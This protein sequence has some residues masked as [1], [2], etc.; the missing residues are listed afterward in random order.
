MTNVRSKGTFRAQA[1]ERSGRAAQSKPL[2]PRCRD[3]RLPG[4]HTVMLGGLSTF[5]CDAH[6]VDDQDE[7]ECGVNEDHKWNPGDLECRRCGADLSK[8]NEEE[9]SK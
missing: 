4:I 2:P 9:E 1:A 6:V 8:W 7:W 3:C 5:F